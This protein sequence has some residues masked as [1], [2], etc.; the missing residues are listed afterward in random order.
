MLPVTPVAIATARSIVVQAL[1]D[2]HHGVFRQTETLHFRGIAMD[3]PVADVPLDRILLNPHARRFATQRLNDASWMRLYDRPFDAETQARVADLHQN[4]VLRPGGAHVRAFDCLHTD[5]S[6]RG[7]RE[8]GIITRAGVLIDGN[9][10]AVA[11]RMLGTKAMRAI[12]LPEGATLA[13]LHELE[14]AL[15]QRSIARDWSFTNLLLAAEELLLNQGLEDREA[16]RHLGIPPQ[17]LATWR[18]TLA[19][20]RHVQ[21]VADV[22]PDG[23]LPLA[24]FDDKQPHLEDID[25][26]FLADEHAGDD[27]KIVEFARL[28]GLMAGVSQ[29]SLRKVGLASVFQNHSE[30]AALAS[31][32]TTATPRSEGRKSPGKH[33][34]LAALAELLRIAVCAR[35]ILLAKDPRELVKSERESR[36][37]EDIDTLTAAVCR[38]AKTVPG[39]DRRMWRA[40]RQTGHGA[41]ALLSAFETALLVDTAPVFDRMSLIG[42]AQEALD[43]AQR[44][45]RLALDLEARAT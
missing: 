42:A 41:W 40:V 37:V 3:L 15:R 9:A 6:R 19:R 11:M 32:L 26:A 30:L 20:I 17:R 10:R 29:S 13:E 31:T 8:P 35:S 24:W 4:D 23:R 14:L 39:G 27:S 44:L 21:S 34:T 36:A 18:R 2:W 38:I 33:Q 1:N 28:V 12:V 43:H 7:Q 16:A 5:L 25:R 22:F 45:H